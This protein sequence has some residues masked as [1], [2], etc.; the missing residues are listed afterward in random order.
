MTD[1][2]TIGPV[3]IEHAHLFDSNTFSFSN[4]ATRIVSSGSAIVTKGQ[5]DEKYSFELIC[6]YDEAL[7]LKGLVEQGELV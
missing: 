2:C 4:S 3:S 1:L 5:F 6:S 7:Q